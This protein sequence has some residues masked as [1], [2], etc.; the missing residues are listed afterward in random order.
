VSFSTPCHHRDKVLPVVDVSHN[1][2]LVNFVSVILAKSLRLDVL[3][4]AS[5]SR[6]MFSLAIDY[7]VTGF[8]VVRDHRSAS[9]ATP[10]ASPFGAIAESIRSF[11][12]EPERFSG[13]RED[14]GHPFSRKR[15]VWKNKAFSSQVS[16][17]C[18]L[19][20]VESY[21]TDGTSQQNL[22]CTNGLHSGRLHDFY[23]FVS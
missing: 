22:L 17:L 21:P 11:R 6:G 12:T 5:G 20:P 18:S 13:P 4:T 1:P 8:E 14:G 2:E 10:S 19:I 23:I 3:G 7:R 15:F 16:Q 9:K